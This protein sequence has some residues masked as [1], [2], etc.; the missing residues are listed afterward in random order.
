MGSDFVTDNCPKFRSFVNDEMIKHVM[1]FV[2]IPTTS[3][4]GSEGGKSAVIANKH[5]V[6]VVFGH[7]VLMPK[8]A[9]LDPTLTV[10]L[11]P[12]MTAATG[13]D[14]LFH[15]YSHRLCSAVCAALLLLLLFGQLGRCFVVNSSLFVFLIFCCFSLSAFLFS[16]PYSLEAFMVD[17]AIAGPRDGMDKEFCDVAD[18]HAL[19]GIELVLKNLPLVMKNPAD[20]QARLNMQVASLYGAKAFAKGDLG[21]VHSSAHALGSHYHMHHG[22][23]IARMAVPVLLYSEAKLSSFPAHVQQSYKN[24]VQ[25]FVKCGYKGET[26]SQAVRAFIQQFSCL[27]VGIKDVV[28]S[29]GVPH[30][31]LTCVVCDSDD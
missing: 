9:V 22:A 14:A 25:L 24:L 1:P 12:M 29:E 8:L 21:G 3:G 7:P 4:T 11:P 17:R 5:G 15:R 27:D 16:L 30:F 26:L 23:S 10:G 20:L 6:K 19:I 13:V 28:K 18:D 2:A 31:L